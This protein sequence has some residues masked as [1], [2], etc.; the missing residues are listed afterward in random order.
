MASLL[1]SHDPGSEIDIFIFF[2]LLATSTVG[3]GLLDPKTMGVGS[4]EIAL[5]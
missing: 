3:V 5:D 2:K 4:L 1:F